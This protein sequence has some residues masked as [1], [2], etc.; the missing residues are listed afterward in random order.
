MEDKVAGTLFNKTV[1]CLRTKLQQQSSQ[2]EELE[3]RK[4]EVTDLKQVSKHTQA[5]VSLPCHC[6]KQKN[7]LV[8]VPQINGIFMCWTQQQNQELGVQL[9]T[10][11]HSEADLMEVNQRLRE[12]LDRMRGELRMA[13]TQAEK[14]QHEAE[15]LLQSTAH[16]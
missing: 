6:G 10:L 12:T 4:A 7:P 5:K 8:C 2:L 1:P 15:R 9:G 3:R 14:S 13:R 16:P 11:T